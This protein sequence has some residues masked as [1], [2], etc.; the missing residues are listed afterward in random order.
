MPEL[1]RSMSGKTPP[2]SPRANRSELQ[3]AAR[4]SQSFRSK[5]PGA[6]IASEESASQADTVHVDDFE[7]EG[8]FR[9]LTSAEKLQVLRSKPPLETLMYGI[10]LGRLERAVRAYL[11]NGIIHK[12]DSKL[13]RNNLKQV[14]GR[15]TFSLSLFWWFADSNSSDVVGMLLSAAEHHGHEFLSLLYPRPCAQIRTFFVSLP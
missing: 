11:T 7:T 1:M 3:K 6:T 2:R 5:S 14:E 15:K 12:S 9:W 4:P 13:L 10:R 8:G